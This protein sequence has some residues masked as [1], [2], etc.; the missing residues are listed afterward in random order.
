M[1][2]AYDSGSFARVAEF[3]CEYKSTDDYRFAFSSK[4]WISSFINLYKPHVNFLVLSTNGSNYF[5]LS[6]CN[7]RLV[8]TG[9][10][11]NDFNGFLIRDAA[12]TFNFT[13]ILSYFAAAN[14]ALHW[15]NLFE[16]DLISNLKTSKTAKVLQGSTVGLKVSLGTGPIRISKR[17]EKMY[18]RYASGLSFHRMNGRDL[19]LN[20]KPLELLF[21]YR[22][23]KLL[24]RKAEE[25]NLS[26]E[27]DFESFIDE[28]TRLPSIW[29]NVFLDSCTSLNDNRCRALSLYLTKDDAAICYLRGHLP[30]TNFV[31]YGLMLD[32][33]SINLCASKGISTIDLS[34]GDESYKYRLGA[35]EYYLAT[36]NAPEFESGPAN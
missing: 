4:E 18:G 28:V 31:S 14:Y 34:R 12:D 25:Y 13:D 27:P 17:I 26:F 9:D 2:I 20:R 21:R 30:S 16:I 32:F 22:R 10:P 5:S 6:S 7:K 11:F 36:L 33:W 8:F 24:S 35:K 1:I 23:S 29:D 15:P 19:H 3:L